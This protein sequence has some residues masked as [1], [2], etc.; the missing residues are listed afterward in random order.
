MR[1]KY[2]DVER[3][4]MLDIGHNLRKTLETK[5]ISQK[6]LA[7][8]TGLSTSAISDYITAKTLMSPGNVQLISDMLKVKKSDIDPSFRG[9][10]TLEDLQYGKTI[11]LP[12]V[13]RISCGNGVLAYQEIESY[14]PTPKAWLNGGE[15]FYLRAKGDSMIGAR[16]QE[17]DLLLIRRQE[18][19]ED[20]EIAAVMVE[21][22]AVL[23]RVYK[24]GNTLY[25]QSENPSYA[26]IVIEESEAYT[27]KII[28]KLKKIIVEP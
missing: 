23:K 25:L 16:I 7:D 21:D 5:R 15:Y 2:S 22:E 12:I 28:G 10:I 20:G 14:E 17:G 26:P 6:E 11:D 24:R 4:L 9:T 19:V 18:E 27:T 3:K 13:G 1:K 8:L